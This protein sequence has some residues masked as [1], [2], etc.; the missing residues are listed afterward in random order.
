M[1]STVEI[2]MSA[3]EV[4]HHQSMQVAPQEG[5]IKSEDCL[6]RA[7]VYEDYLS[8]DSERKAKQD[9]LIEQAARTA[10]EANRIL[11]L[12]NN[13]GNVAVS[14]EEATKEIRRSAKIGVEAVAKDPSITPEQ[15]HLSWCETKLADGWTY[16]AIRD[17]DLKYHPCLV[18]YDE[19]PEVQRVKDAMFRA[20]VLAVL[21][22]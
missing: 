11:Q 1:S 21:G 12:A 7:R 4:A 5:G 20:V 9:N 18:A 3:L 14:W 17:N 16:G 22:L 2:R 8:G 13:E 10:H 19:L 15:L 6:A